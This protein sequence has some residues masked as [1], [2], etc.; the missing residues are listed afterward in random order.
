MTDGDILVF[1][2]G[3]Q[4]FGMKTA[5]VREVFHL[6]A[7]TSV[8]LAPVFVIGLMNLR[9]RVVTLICAR[10]LLGMRARGT[11]GVA[12]GFEIDG[13]SFGLI[14]DAVEGVVIPDAGPLA[15]PHDLPAAAAGLSTGI[16][17][18]NGRHVTLLDATRMVDFDVAMA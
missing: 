17:R 7:P 16:C 11:A 13:D 8:P 15:P 10:L 3:R 6:A 14:V 2:L 5:A 4:R 1:R 12:V 9:G 18:V